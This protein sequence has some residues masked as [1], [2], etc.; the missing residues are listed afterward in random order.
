MSNM[1]RATVFQLNLGMGL[2]IYLNEEL[3]ISAVDPITLKLKS[4]VSF[5]IYP[6]HSQDESFHKVLKNLKQS[7]DALTKPTRSTVHFNGRIDSILAHVGFLF[8]PITYL[9]IETLE[10]LE[11]VIKLRSWLEIEKQLQNGETPD[12]H[13]T[14]QFYPALSDELKEIL[15][16]PK[17]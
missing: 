2:P 7:Y 15:D 14:I 11:K 9:V 1:T 16:G 5:T 4:S 3:M 8:E 17:E 6:D 13:K 10:D 12:G